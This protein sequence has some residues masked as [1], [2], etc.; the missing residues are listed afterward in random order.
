MVLLR[1]LVV[2][3]RVLQ[4]FIVATVAVFGRVLIRLRGSLV[5]GRGTVQ[6]VGGGPMPCSPSSDAV[7]TVASARWRTYWEPRAYGWNIRLRW[8]SSP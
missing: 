3:S 4:V 6:A 2:P 1:E 7:A 8:Y 5:T